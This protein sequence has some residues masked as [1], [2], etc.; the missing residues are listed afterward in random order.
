MF[1]VMRNSISEVSSRAHL[2]PPRLRG[3]RSCW[4][5]RLI[6]QFC[7]VSKRLF[8]HRGEGVGNNSRGRL[9][10][11]TTSGIPRREGLSN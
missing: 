7:R 2:C 6:N 5:N 9:K 1:S 3:S 11:R 4:V 8:S 10:A